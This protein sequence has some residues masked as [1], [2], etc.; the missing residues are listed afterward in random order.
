M[1]GLSLYFLG[2]CQ[3]AL[4]SIFLKSEFGHESMAISFRTARRFSMGLIGMLSLVCLALSLF[5]WG[6][7]YSKSKNIGAVI[8]IPTGAFIGSIWTIFTKVVHKPQLVS[9]EATWTFA[10]LPFEILLGLFSVNLNIA[11]VPTAHTAYLCLAT[12]IWLNA[13]LVAIYVTTIILLALLTQVLHDQDVWSRDIDS[14][15]SPFPLHIIVAYAFSSLTRPFS[16]VTRQNRP[17]SPVSKEHCLPGCTCSRKLPNS[18]SLADWRTL[19]PT[20]ENTTSDVSG[21]PHSLINIRVPTA[22]ERPKPIAVTLRS[23]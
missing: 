9:V 22:M 11:N 12:L 8:V 1:P 16:L 21:S 15:P 18:S 6:A 5:L 19:G 7:G 3:S 14:S 13:A 4:P 17:T 23:R 10:L 20:L 2:L